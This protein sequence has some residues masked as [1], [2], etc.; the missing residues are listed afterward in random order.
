MATPAGRGCAAIPPASIPLG[1][2]SSYGREMLQAQT[3][4][5]KPASFLPPP[6]APRCQRALLTAGA[7]GF[8]LAKASEPLQAGVSTWADLVFCPRVCSASK[9][10]LLLQNSPK[11]FVFCFPLALSA[12]SSKILGF[13]ESQPSELK[14][15]VF[16]VF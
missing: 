15:C 6:A 12:P 7:A 1:A 4:A 13:S 10:E 14:L 5:P 2:S 16:H 8:V 9:R 3:P 11:E